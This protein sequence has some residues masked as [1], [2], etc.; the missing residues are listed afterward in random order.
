[1]LNLCLKKQIQWWPSKLLTTYFIFLGR[2]GR[3]C[4]LNST[5]GGYVNGKRVYG[6]YPQLRIIFLSE[7]GLNLSLEGVEQVV[8]HL[9]LRN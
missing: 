4:S 5:S 2:L 8:Q 3:M 6:C 1:M 7:R 9:E